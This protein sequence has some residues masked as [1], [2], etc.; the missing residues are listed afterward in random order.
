MS[1]SG[2]SFW[3]LGQ[4]VVDRV[5]RRSRL[6][7]KGRADARAG[8]GTLQARPIFHCDFHLSQIC[9]IAQAEVSIKIFTFAAMQR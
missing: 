6:P 4:R 7:V 2:E 1:P 8:V 5:D 3:L 9:Q